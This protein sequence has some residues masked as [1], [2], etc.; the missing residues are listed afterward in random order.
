M[1][2][3]RLPF[4]CIQNALS[5]VREFHK[6]LLQIKELTSQQKKCGNGPMLVGFTGLTMLLIILKQKDWWNGGMAFWNLR[7][8]IPSHLWKCKL[9][10]LYLGI[11]GP[12]SIIHAW[13]SSLLACPTNFSLLAPKITSHEPCVC[14]WGGCSY[15]PPRSLYPSTALTWS[16]YNTFPCS[17][18]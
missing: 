2:L 13:V 3:P 14:V 7:A 11:T 1:L 15:I 18:I 6:A 12:F 10:G 4:I 5:T 8:N 16:I 9:K 17:L